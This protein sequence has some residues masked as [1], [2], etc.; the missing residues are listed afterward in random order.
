MTYINVHLLQL[1]FVSKA[2]ATRII[3]KSSTM[4]TTN[5]LPEESQALVA[6]LRDAVGIEVSSLLSDNDCMRFVR[7]RK[8]DIAKATVMASEW[9][10]WWQT[11][12]EDEEHKGISPSTILKNRVDDPNEQLYTDLVHNSATTPFENNTCSLVLIEYKV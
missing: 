4:S 1:H 7:A 9:A 11:P 10:T 5:C 12:F 2:F 3:H 6:A 8:G